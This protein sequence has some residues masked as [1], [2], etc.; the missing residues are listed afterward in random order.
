MIIAVELLST[1]CI[2]VYPDPS[3]STDIINFQYQLPQK[4]NTENI[5]SPY[6]PHSW[7]YIFQYFAVYQAII[8]RI[9]PVE[10]CD[11]AA[12]GNTLSQ[13]S[14]TKIVNLPYYNFLVF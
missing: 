7:G 12:L 8:V 6:C 5:N 14:N 4:D 9:G 3:R 10:N 1:K 13:E 2:K 11:V